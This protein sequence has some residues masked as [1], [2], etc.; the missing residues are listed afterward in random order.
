M[1]AEGVFVCIQN[2]EADRRSLTGYIGPTVSVTPLMKLM[3]TCEIMKNFR[4][5]KKKN[6]GASINVGQGKT[7]Q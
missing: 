7:E 1:N 6:A 3:E 2:P 4:T 5:A